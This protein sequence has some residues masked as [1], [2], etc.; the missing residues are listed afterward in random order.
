MHTQVITKFAVASDKMLDELLYLLR[1]WMSEHPEVV[2]AGTYTRK[3]LVNTM[4]SFSS[5]WLIVYA[6]DEPA[7]F[8]FLTDGG[9]RPAIFD[10]KR[11]V[12]LAAFG[13]LEAY[14]GGAA[15]TS[16]L[17]KC[18]T[19]YKGRDAIWTLPAAA[20]RAFLESGGFVQHAATPYWVKEQL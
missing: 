3:I 10:H 7:G 14:A 16:L 20:N 19:I 8:A 17:E 13:V 11:V 2:P 4:N 9:E 18:M 12:Q 15:E 5:Q 6:G 1:T